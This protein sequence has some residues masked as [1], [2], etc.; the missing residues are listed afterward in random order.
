[1]LQK[2]DVTKKSLGQGG[3]VGIPGVKSRN[4]NE[5]KSVLDTSLMKKSGT[6]AFF[7]SPTSECASVCE[8]ERVRASE[9]ERER[10]RASESERYL[11]AHPGIHLNA[12]AQTFT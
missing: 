8:R 3:G 12:N 2:S 6:G 4:F 9:S 10:A 11:V 7:K 1:M 5:K